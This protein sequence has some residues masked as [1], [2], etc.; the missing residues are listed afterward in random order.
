[1]ARGRKPLYTNEYEGLVLEL[2]RAGV[3][4]P[5]YREYVKAPPAVKR[6]LREILKKV[7]DG[8]LPEDF[9]IVGD[10]VSC[11]VMPDG[12]TVYVRGSRLR[13][14]QPPFKH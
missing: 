10:W 9:V 2:R 3:S 12:R 5:S 13:I 8:E 11:L 6:T 7:N 14:R 4:A 1:L